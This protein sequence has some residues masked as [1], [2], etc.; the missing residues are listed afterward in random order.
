VETRRITLERFGNSQLFGD[1]ES[2]RRGLP[3]ALFCCCD[4]EIEFQIMTIRT[5]EPT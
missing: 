1:F 5:A 2:V 3:L 4:F